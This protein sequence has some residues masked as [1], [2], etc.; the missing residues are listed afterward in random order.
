MNVCHIH[1]GIESGEAGSTRG[2]AGRAG[3]AGRGGDAVRERAR[4]ALARA[5]AIGIA[6]RPVP[7][8]WLHTLRLPWVLG[9]WRWVAAAA[10]DLIHAHDS[11]ATSLAIGAG[12]RLGVPVVSPRRVASP[13]R[14]NARSARKYS[15]RSLA[16][17]IAI[18]DT[19]RDVFGQSGYPEDRIHVVPSGL[20]RRG[21]GRGG[22]GR[23]AADGIPRA[24]A[25]HRH[26]QAL[27]EE[28][29]G[30]AGPGGGGA[31]I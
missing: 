21:A 15:A 11:R 7:S 1:T 4:R 17:V 20:E 28:E 31:A 19:V 22:P 6:V 30:G 8:R 9:R 10:P 2:S 18:S 27:A 14:R 5:A 13:L 23:R 29:L 16:A 26:R 3:A 12:R 24:L 25:G